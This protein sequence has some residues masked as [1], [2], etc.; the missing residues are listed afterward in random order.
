[1]SLAKFEIFST[2]V[3]L[4]SF[5]KASEKLGLTQSAVSHAIASLEREYGF[6]LLTRGRSGIHLT[7]NGERVLSYM[8][9]MLKI[10]KEMQ[11]EI[12]QLNGLV[13]GEVRIGTFSSVSAQWLP[14][15]LQHFK[16]QY[17]HIDIQLFE[18]D[19]DDIESWIASGY[20]DFGFVSLPTSYQ[21]EVK[22]LK[23]D[24]MVCLVEQHHPLA[25]LDNVHWKAMEQYP[26]IRAKKGSD[27]DL[28][29]ILKAHHID[30][31]V[32]FE[33]FDD[34]AI[35]SMVSHDIGISVLSE[36]AVYRVPDNIRIV[37]LQPEEYRTIG[38]AAQSFSTLAPAT[39]KLID[40]LTAYVER[41][42]QKEA[43]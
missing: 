14:E 18:G 17:P 25:Q 20:V 26:F 6:S 1:M 33:L 23:K 21:F 32:R 27:N 30:L 8:N 13:V 2:I 36:L 42:T 7:T 38:I 29:R 37:H 31:N 39:K 3:A 4:G 16:S 10:E 19:Y 43:H 28:K 12:A 40:Y 22:P 41:T 24:R 11:Q 9:A 5:A 15:I 34:Q 35:F